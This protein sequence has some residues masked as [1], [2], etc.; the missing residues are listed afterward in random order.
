MSPRLPNAPLLEAIFE[1]KWQLKD[2]RNNSFVDNNYS[3]IIG[4]LNA[5]INEKYPK[6]DPVMPHVTMP[7]EV[8]QYLVQHRFRNNSS[9]W[10]LYQIGPGILTFNQTEDYDWDV[11]QEDLKELIT[12][13]L[14]IYPKSSNLTLIEI[15]LRYIDGLIFNFDE[16]NI[17]QALE[18]KMDIK[19]TLPN[20]IFSNGKISQ[21]PLAGNLLVSLPSM[22]PKGISVLNINRGQI[23]GN[24]G[25]IIE[26]AVNSKGIDVPQTETEI[27][28][29]INQAHIITDD[30]FINLFAPIMNDFKKEV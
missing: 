9:G 14:T 15:T 23:N 6:H 21:H 22:E 7:E 30:L 24:D 12:A 1:L 5:K 2:E 25:I 11:Y 29:W 10:P 26:M 16:D 20:T 27:F 18:N 8:A 3:L 13:F 17:I 28:D 19:L 4:S